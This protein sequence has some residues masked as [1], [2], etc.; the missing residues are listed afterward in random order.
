MSK[1]KGN[2]DYHGQALAQRLL[3]VLIIVAA[4]LG[5]IV[6]YDLQDVAVAMY[7]FG[8]GFVLALLV[9]VPPWPFFQR[10]HVQ[11]LPA[12]SPTPSS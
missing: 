11:W 10:H 7:L 5:L 6:G 3:H 12:S 8:A 4:T 9:C 1:L 2:I